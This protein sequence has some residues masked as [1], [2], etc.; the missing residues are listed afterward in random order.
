MN[1]LDVTRLDVT[2]AVLIGLTIAT[3]LVP[4][5]VP[6][7]LFA[8]A[9]VLVLAAVKGHRIVLDY[10][11]LRAAPAPWRGLV[12]TWIAILVLFA[13]LASAAVALI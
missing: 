13:W 2:W 11:D 7:A 4:W 10:L 6:G 5:L 3:V 8:N 12:S 1:R 9:V